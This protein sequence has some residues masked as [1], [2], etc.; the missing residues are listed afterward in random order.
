MLYQIY[1]EFDDSVKYQEIFE[2]RGIMSYTAS[3]SRGVWRGKPENSIVFEIFDD[4]G[5]DQ[6][7]VYAAAET[8]RATSGQD[9]VYLAE[10]PCHAV[11]SFPS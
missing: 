2:E 1:A 6:A 4:N 5:E 11:R 9:V 3:Y 10:I 7:K 8:I